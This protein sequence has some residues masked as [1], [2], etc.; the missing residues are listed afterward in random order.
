MADINKINA[1]TRVKNDAITLTSS[2]YS[3]K[4]VN[5]DR[6]DIDF[7][8]TTNVIGQIRLQRFIEV[9][10]TAPTSNVSLSDVGYFLVPSYLTGYHINTL[11]GINIVAGTGSDTIITLTRIRSGITVIVGILTITANNT[12]GVNSSGF[13]NTD[14]QVN[15]V[16]ELNVTSVA[17]SAPQGL[18]IAIEV[19]K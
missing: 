7:S 15:D 3:F 5:P 4:N 6:K 8:N 12:L 18:I 16:L 9:S 13:S 10:I 1:G 14:L 11:R 2:G 17:G 19:N